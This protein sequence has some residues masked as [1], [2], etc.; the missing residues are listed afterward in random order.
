MEFN[1]FLQLE[2]LQ[3][4]AGSV[5][6]VMLLTGFFKSIYQYTISNFGMEEDT[7]IYKLFAVISSVIVVFTFNYS[8]GTSWQ[9]VLLGILN[10]LVL[11]AAAMGTYNVS[12]GE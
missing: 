5:A 8:G 11:S 2:Q 4:F 6:A 3:T 9:E 10:S 12:V 7:S 1:N